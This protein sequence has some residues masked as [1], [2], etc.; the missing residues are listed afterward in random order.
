[1]TVPSIDAVVPARD[2]EQTVASVVEACLGCDW[3]RQ[4]IVVD[5]GSADDTAA[6]AA[7]AG[8]KVVRRDLGDAAVVGN[9]LAR[10]EGSKAHAMEMGVEA[11]DAQTILFV[12][13]DLLGI[14]SGHLDE[15]ARPYLDGRA[16]MSLGCFDYGWL[17]RLVVRLPPTSGERI[18]PRWVFDAVPT[19]K[20]EGYTIEMMINGV[21]AAGGCP[22]TARVMR[23]VSHRTKRDKFGFLEGYRRTG[24][25]FWDLLSVLRV[26]HLRTYWY[27]LRRLTVEA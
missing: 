25:M 5:D 10:A 18:I 11:S 26:V 1:V 9:A 13:A 22:T 19:S 12:D 2:E 24:R 4:V 27:Y 21:V 15:I 17:N 8:A 7:A 14:T 20:R 16:V 6:R 23:G 3:I